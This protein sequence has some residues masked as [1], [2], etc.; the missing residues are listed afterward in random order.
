[1]HKIIL[2]LSLSTFLL[3]KGVVVP[4]DYVISDDEKLPYVYSDEYAGMMLDM[5]SY[6]EEV[7]AGYEKE[8]GFE[9]DDKLYV[10]MASQNNQI[11]NGFSTQFP[12]NSQL[13]YT[14][15]A[16]LIDYFCATSWLKTLVIHETAHNFQLNPK[17]NDLSRIT[18][19]V[20]GNTPFSMFGI[21]PLFPVPNVTESS[22]VLEGNAVMNESRYGNGGRLFSGYALA[23]VVTLAKAGKITPELMYN[24]TLE[25][26]YG[27]KFYMIGGFF[28]QFL[29][30]KY[31]V[32]K[33]NGYFKTYSSQPFPFFTN[34]MFEEQYGKNFE[35]LLAEFV[36]DIEAKHKGFE[37]T[38]GKTLARSQIFTPLNA[39]DNEIYTLVGDRTSAPKIL[40]LH[41]ENKQIAYK[42]GSWLVGEVFKRDKEYYVQSEAKTSPTKIVMGLFHED[43]TLVEGESS[44][45]VQGYKPDGKEVYFDVKTS[46][47][48]PH[49][50]VDGK[51]YTQSHSSVHVDKKGDLYYFK[52]EGKKRILYKNKTALFDYEGHYGF[53]TDV[54]ESGAIYFVAS[55]K[56]GTT[57]YK[58]ANGVSERV[59]KGD[60]VIE[61]KLLNSKE[62]LVVTMGAEGYEY[63][64]ITLNGD[65]KEVATPYSPHYKGAL[66]N[67]TLRNRNFSTDSKPLNS[68]PYTPLTQLRYSSL[69]QAMS[70]G[71]YEGFGLDVSANFADPL[72]QNSLSAILSYNKLR[73]IGGLRYDNQAHQLEF[74][75]A[76]YGVKHDEN[77]L[78][79]DEE[80]DYGYEAYLNLP[81]L[82]TGY[83]RANASLAYTKAYDN[84]YR[85]PLTMS[86]DIYN[87][88]QYGFSKYANELNALS[89]FATKDRE[90]SI[91][92]GT[93][94]FKHDLF[95]QTYVGA[96]G[97]YMKSDEVDSFEEK[98]I[99]VSDGFSDLQ[100]DKATLNMPT[101]SKTYYAK[102]AKMAEL[103]LAKV[104]DASLYFYS[105]PLSL[106]RESLYLKQRF[107]D[108]DFTDSVNRQY[109]ESTVGIEL[110]LLFLH[111][112]TV[113]LNIEWIYNEDVRDREQVRFMFGLGF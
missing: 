31:G 3:A 55:S 10:G 105:F 27:E 110:D 30:E 64:L 104:F 87:H 66:E 70:Y 96:K 92:G 83:W 48:N 67:S 77:K 76:V 39:N 94:S 44:R 45:V 112:L 86:L 74:G 2:S 101:I 69:N 58:F 5:K 57:L 17:E 98:G 34:W 53:V 63:K 79:I 8:Y 78:G 6:Q 102:E 51:F 32:E 16:G 29:V 89:L 75:G 72:M 60:D 33:V 9:L 12:F 24:S 93:Y 21:L 99:E 65:E 59:T 106:Q 18:H 47:E 43:A 4:D 61:F 84:I 19:K 91:L 35:E 37:V 52:Q 23:E 11:A 54:D 14:S 56:D 68:R 28:Q 40:E 13:F 7:I 41:K 15:G 38:D 103:S 71:S 62:A 20:L 25:F 46:I 1:M 108:I 42:S 82:A 49:V 81:F 26:P 113:P 36:E 111:N 85:E 22:F 109:N 95:W 97:T 50:Y 100:S 107:Y 90:S 88:K 80:R 73:T